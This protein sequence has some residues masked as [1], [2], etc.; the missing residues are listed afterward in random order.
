MTARRLQTIGLV[1][2]LA[3]LGFALLVYV[4]YALNL[5]QF[6]FDYDQGEGFELVDSIMLARGEM[7]YRNTEAYPFYSS[8]VPCAGHPVCVAVWQRLL[9]WA[10]A[11][12]SGDAHHSRRNWLRCAAGQRQPLVRCAGRPGVP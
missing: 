5:M 12:V 9:V 1:I 4:A 8:P 6:P 2:A 3:M 7:P 10:S 11:G